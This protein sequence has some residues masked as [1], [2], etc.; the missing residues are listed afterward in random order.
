MYAKRMSDGRVYEM[1]E[2]GRSLK[3]DQRMEAKT[4]SKAG[5]AD[6]GDRAA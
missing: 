5:V 3:S 2:K 4:R 6:Q 1:D